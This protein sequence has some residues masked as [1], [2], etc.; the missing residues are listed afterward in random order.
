[1]DGKD[2]EGWEVFQR[3]VLDVLRQY[4]GYFD[5]FERIGSLSDS[6]PDCFARLTR[7][8]KKEIWIVDAK[9]KPEIDEDDLGRMEKYVEM[10]RSNP[11]DVGLELSEL[12][13]HEVRGIFVTDSG[14]LS[15]KDF[16]QVNFP[17]FHQFLQRE[18][19][20]TDQDKL[21]R[22]VSKMMERRQLSQSQARLLFRSLKPFE[23]RLDGGLDALETLE[24]EFVGIELDRPPISSYDYNIPVDAVM[25]HEERDQVFLFDIPYSEDAV[26]EVKEK[27]S[28]VKDRLGDLEKPVYYSAINT[29]SP[30]DS[31]YLLQPGEVRR[32]VME[33]AGIV[34]PE[35]ILG[36]FTPKIGT[37]KSYGDSYTEIVDSAGVG[38]RARVES[39]DDVNHRVE[40]I[41]P[42]EAI[43]RLKD[44]FLNSRE[45]GEIS[46]N[47]FRIDIKVTPQ[48]EVDYGDRKEPFSS[49]R[50][51]VKSLYQ[52][53]VNPV[54]GKKVSKTV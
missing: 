22:D 48:L 15:L 5:F 19:I 21:V 44:R 51:S 54:L 1:M 32:E 40:V 50:E 11:I 43:N 28:E 14:D 52:P 30:R 38:F 2:D 42:E 27:V 24:T 47:R 25:R 39:Y 17:A 10:V 13:E 41:L 23:N 35:Q 45:I 8:D 33:T 7:E 36:L 9:N 29:F 31:D 12:A 26:N 34:S 6:R 20:Y 18:L 3:D 4:E 49:F 37:E 53:A 16:E 46:S